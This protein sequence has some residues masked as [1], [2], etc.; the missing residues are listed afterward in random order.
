[1][2]LPKPSEPRPCTLPRNPSYRNSVV[3]R[4]PLP[5][6]SVVLSWDT[7][8]SLV[9]RCGSGQ[10]ADVPAAWTAASVN[11]RNAKIA[12]TPKPSVAD[13]SK[14]GTGPLRKRA[15]IC[16]EVFSAMSSR[17]SPSR[18]RPAI[19]A[20]PSCGIPV[21][22]NGATAS[23]SDRATSQFV[24]PR[25]RTSSRP[26]PF[27]S[28]ASGSKPPVQAGPSSSD[29]GALTVQALRRT[30]SV[31]LDKCLYARS[32]QPSSLKSRGTPPRNTLSGRSVANPDAEIRAT[33]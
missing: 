32:V 27:Q 28:S 30:R 24:V 12:V 26:S 31:W 11:G 33:V 3:D 4:Y 7:T 23:P 16:V 29:V 22:R 21:S 25:T 14:S 15:R 10:P 18:S 20:A 17:P 19:A 1:M 13:A 6:P 9:C 8:R 5:V 2:T